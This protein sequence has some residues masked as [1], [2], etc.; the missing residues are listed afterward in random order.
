[1]PPITRKLLIDWAGPQVV[2]DAEILL[3]KQLVV[4][5]EYEPPLIRGTVLW[6]NRP[7]KTSLE[8]HKDGTVSNHCPCR[9]NMERGIICSHVIA[10]GLQLVKRATDPMREAK[11]Q[12]E[13]RRATRLA[14][15]DETSYIQRVTADTPGALSANVRLTLGAGWQTHAA[16]G[17]IP[18]R[19]EAEYQGARLLLHEVPRDIPLAFSKADES[20]LFV[21]EDISEGP[22]QGLLEVSIPDFLNILQL[23]RTLTIEQEP[24]SPLT[25]GETP[26]TTF[27]RMDLDRESGELILIAHTELPFVKEGEFPLYLVAGKNGWIYGADHLWPVENVLPEP[28]HGIYR[29]PVVVSRRD[30]LRFLNHELPL[31][32]KCARIESDISPDLFTV[33]PATPRFRLIT[34]GSPAS[35]SATLYVRYG[36][37]E[38]VA[39]KPD[40]REHFGIPDPTDLMRYTVRNSPREGEALETLS[41]CGM[42]GLAGDDLTPIVDNR[43]VLHFLGSHLPALRRRGW[44]VELEG[45]VGTYADELD[46]ATPVVRVAEAGSGWFDIGFDFEDRTGASISHAEIQRALRKGESFITRGDRTI[47]LDSDA[48]EAMQD[49][50]RDC[51]SGESDSA[52]H[53]KMA[54]I[55]ASFVKSSL[56]SLD[57]V[58]VEAAPTW[59][60]RA[61]QQNRAMKLVPIPLPENLEKILRPYQKDGVYWLRFLEENSFC[62]ILADE[63]GL[64]KTLQALA[65]IQLERL[66]PEAAGRATLIVCPTSLVQNWAEE[67]RR[68]VPRLRVVDLT[69]ADRQERWTMMAQTDLAI[70][71]YAILR[72]D[73]SRYLEYEFASVLLDEAQHIKNKSTQNAL[74]AKQ[75]KARNRLVLTGTPV[76]NS[77]SDVWSIMDFLMPGYLGN[78]DAFRSKYEL[79]ILRGGPDAETAQVKLRRKLHPF[80][81]RRLKS[82]VARDLPP[83]I[84]KVAS[85]ELSPDQKLVYGQILESSR[86]QIQELVAQ[87]GFNK[88]RMEI[89]ATLMRLRQTCCHL[90]LLKMPTL[91]PKFP[92]AKLDLFFELIDEAVD[93]G[94]RVLVFS[95]FVSMLHIL[96]DELQKRE[97]TYCYLD[98]S[99]KERLKIVH[100]FNTERSIPVFLISLKAG[101]TGLNLTGADM[102][103]HFDPWWNPAVENQATDRA[104]RIGQHRTV[105][106]LKLI[107]LGTVEEK[108]LQLQARKQSIIDATIESDEKVIQQLTWDD[109]Q[110]LLSL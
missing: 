45:T 67:A 30:V 12:A 86:R 37:I 103:I 72:R 89:L 77:V 106:S 90:S 42:S 9:A 1:M 27:I 76:E 32:S 20:L 6:S 65:W 33:E 46:S 29:E 41:A 92:S 97:L 8:L 69:G 82:E 55:Y 47:L 56:D 26:M 14:A 110:E 109:V 95:Q 58:D 39:G 4:E 105:Y 16:G 73:L 31:L 104:Y 108:V 24:G 7:L 25:V 75:L 80:L 96:R 59:M 79:A 50:F 60:A 107:T 23:R 78:H 5:A 63:M 2:R 102:V 64:G 17:R 38:L 57:G 88:C 66:A 68:F 101:G 35:L 3:E 48:I 98:G 81:L 49:V 74:A 15:I 84:E 94:H 10:L 43:R 61:E 71:S 85:C 91:Q 83:K 36:D 21:L 53:F 22:A 87:R 100:Q 51:A 62:G 54:G 40:A 52:G 19:C 93:A 28:Y 44:Q 13:L 99:T 70:T 18:L 34:R 11:Y